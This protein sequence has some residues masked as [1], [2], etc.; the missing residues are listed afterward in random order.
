MPSPFRRTH[1]INGR[2]IKVPK[3]GRRLPP[4]NRLLEI[5]GL[6]GAIGEQLGLAW[7]AEQDVQ[8]FVETRAQRPNEQHQRLVQRAL[9][10]LS[11]HFVLG[12]SH[13]LGNL[14]LRLLLLNPDA[15]TTLTGMRRYHKA[16]G[17]PP[18]SDDHHAW[19]TLNRDLLNDLAK[20]AEASGNRFMVR[21]VDTLH[22]LHGSP[23]FQAL[24]TRRG[25]D[26]H[27]RRPQTRHGAHHVVSPR[28]TPPSTSPLPV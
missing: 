17:F 4:P 7:T 16:N 3:R 27:R 9:A 15:T 1:T 10:E 26:Y 2:D 25:L 22:G 18:G 14:T 6:A 11:G 13:S 19:P 24:D 5:H 28:T 23:S 12:A 20:A 8:R 21:A